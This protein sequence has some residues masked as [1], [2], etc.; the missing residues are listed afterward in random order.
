MAVLGS[1]LLSLCFGMLLLS[2]SSADYPDRCMSFSTVHPTTGPGIKI[3]SNIY[4]SNRIYTISVP[5]DSSTNSVVLRAMD[6][7]NN[8]SVGLWQTADGLWKIADPVCNGSVLYQRPDTREGFFRVNWQSP[9]FTNITVEIQA[10]VINVNRMAT[11]SSLKLENQAMITTSPSM[12][13]MTSRT[14]MTSMTSRTSMT[15]MTRPTTTRSP[16]TNRFP[17]TAKTATSTLTTTKSFANRIF[18]S[19]ITDAIQILLV[20]LTSKLLF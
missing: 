2:A 13:S 9:H 3:S 20:F 1:T 6:T 18:L 14:S 17:T 12:T 16:T 10:F 11:F 4:E 15:S 7:N 8:S 5:V 19:P